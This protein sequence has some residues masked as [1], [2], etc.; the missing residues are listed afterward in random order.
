MTKYS[1]HA[2]LMEPEERDLLAV[3]QAV[4]GWW[5]VSLINKEERISWWREARYG[6][7][8]HWGP[9]SVTGGRWKGEPSRGY[10]EIS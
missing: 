7:F 4:V 9:Y 2:A 5:P 3:E 1:E 8:I 6:C 10:A